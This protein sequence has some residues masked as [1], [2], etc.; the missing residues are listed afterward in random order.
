MNL[1]AESSKVV[2]W[3]A[4]PTPLNENGNIDRV[5]VE[6]MV[7]HH[8]SIGVQGLFLAGTCGEGPWLTDSDREALVRTCVE[9]SK[10]RLALCYQV[11]DNSVSRILENIQRASDWGVDSVVIASPYF[12]M[13]AS[14]GTLCEFYTTV[15]DKS[16]LPVGYYERGQ[17]SQYSLDSAGLD[18][19]LQHPNLQ[20]VK[21]SSGLADIRNQLAAA[22]KLRPE[23]QLFNGDEFD[24]VGPAAAGYDG[25]IL[26][27]SIFNAP[28]AV[29]VVEAVRRGDV[30]GAARI[31]A[32]LE[33]VL[34]AVYGEGISSWMAGLKYLLRKLGVFRSTKSLLSY[35]LSDSCRESIDRLLEGEDGLGYLARATGR[36]VCV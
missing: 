9:A 21:D 2:A 10:G 11:T 8:L 31:Q 27:G 26:G 1:A 15:L 30:D 34:Y 33:R 23:L 29:H 3:S 16:P 20:F 12:M 5:S 36:S 28:L 22:K 24:C 35:S 18:A 25:F 19:V 13:N 32:E 7:E 17:H 4:T 6:A 14:A